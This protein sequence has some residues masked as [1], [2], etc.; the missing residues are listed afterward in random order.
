[1]PT[2]ALLLFV[3]PLVASGC[4]STTVVNIG[5]KSSLEKQLMGETEPLSEDELLV[6]SVRDVGSPEAAAGDALTQ[7]AMAARR[8][9]LFNRDD[10]DELKQA[11]CLGE[12]LKGVLATRPCDKVKDADAAKLRD[13]MIEE[14]NADRSAIIDWAVSVDPVLTR[15]DRPQVEELYH[16]L[17][18]ERAKPGEQHQAADR[19]WTQR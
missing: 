1:V 11:G 18:L 5:Q 16:R 8:R 6:A 3:L 2:K 4:I 19:S 9:Q 12:A 10:V 15:A 7:K 17:L 13:R 14:E